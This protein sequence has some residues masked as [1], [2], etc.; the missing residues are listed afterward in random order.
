MQVS[1][2]QAAQGAGRQREA[3]LA[4]LLGA[5]AVA[6]LPRLGG[7]P[8][9]ARFRCLHH[10]RRQIRPLA[11]SAGTTDLYLRRWSI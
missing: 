11:L 2:L 9:A 4:G 5:L 7:G 6:V 1:A 10:V 3:A 8:A